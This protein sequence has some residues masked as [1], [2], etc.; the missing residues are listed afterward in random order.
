MRSYEAKTLSITPKERLRD[1]LP[2]EWQWNRAEQFP[3]VSL[4]EEVELRLW[5]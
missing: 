1:I 2:L 3:Q 4:I 5:E